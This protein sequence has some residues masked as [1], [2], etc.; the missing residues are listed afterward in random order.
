VRYLHRRVACDAHLRDDHRPGARTGHVDE[1]RPLYY[2]PAEDFNGEDSFQVTATDA[3][4]NTP[5]RATT[6][7]VFPRRQAGLPAEGPAGDAGV[8]AQLLADC[9]DV[10]DTLT[11]AIADQGASGE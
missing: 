5:A 11:I 4:G 3:G 7:T 6:V 8:A 2:A 10:D 9:S 1:R